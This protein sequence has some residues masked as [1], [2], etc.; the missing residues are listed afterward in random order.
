MESGV[1]ELGDVM[2]SVIVIGN[3]GSAVGSSALL[4]HVRNLIRSAQKQLCVAEIGADNR[5]ARLRVRMPMNGMPTPQHA[6]ATHLQRK[7]GC[8]V[9]RIVRLPSAWTTG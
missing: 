6:R 9:R 4:G 5:V 2:L 7:E 8:Q 3:G 1:V